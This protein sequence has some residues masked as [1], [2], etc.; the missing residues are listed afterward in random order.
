MAFS[1]SKGQ[2]LITTVPYKILSF[3]HILEGRNFFHGCLVIP[4]IFT[5][6]LC[7]VCVTC[8][9]CSITLSLFSESNKQE[10]IGSPPFTSLLSKD[11]TLTSSYFS[12]IF[13]ILLIWSLNVSLCSLLHF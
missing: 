11:V 5:K 12:L 3:R 13:P 8:G 9:P 6:C 1:F 7:Y 10:I 2:K 4:Q